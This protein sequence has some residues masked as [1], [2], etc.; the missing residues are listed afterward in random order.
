MDPDRRGWPSDP[1]VGSN[2][3]IR[4][5]RSLSLSLGDARQYLS[6]AVDG[7]TTTRATASNQL[8]QHERPTTAFNARRHLSQSGDA[9]AEGV[10]LH[11]NNRLQPRERPIT[12]FSERLNIFRPGGNLQ[13]SRSASS[14]RRNKKRKIQT[15]EHTFICLS[16]MSQCSPPSPMDRGRLMQAG[17]GAKSLCILE[18]TD[19]EDLHHELLDLFPKLQ[20][21]GGYELLRTSQESNRNLEVIPSPPSGYTV[22]YLKGV[23]GQAK[24]YV[25]PLQK[26]L[27]D[28]PLEEGDAVSCAL[29]CI[30]FVCAYVSIFAGVLSPGDLS[31][32]WQVHTSKPAK[33]PY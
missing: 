14:S 19:A 26:D 28:S 16:K 9:S 25:R 12:A 3:R 4:D 11:A 31:D 32:L 30:I 1:R 7:L 24:I 6:Q 18:H 27:D 10:S 5:H 21:G 8:Q 13:R 2:R 23:V 15:W 29:L 20:A 33:K 22:S 17:L